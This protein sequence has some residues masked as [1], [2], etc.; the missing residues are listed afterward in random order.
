MHGRSR[1]T[2]D[3]RIPSMPGRSMSGFHRPGFHQARSEVRYIAKTGV[4]FGG[5]C[6]NRSAGGARAYIN[7]PPN[8]TSCARWHI[9]PTANAEHVLVFTGGGGAVTASAAQ[10]G[11]GPVRRRARNDDEQRKVAWYSRTRLVAQ[12]EEGGSTYRSS[13]EKLGRAIVLERVALKPQSPRVRGIA[14]HKSV[15]PLTELKQNTRYLRYEGRLLHQPIPSRQGFP[16]RSP[17]RFA[18]GA[19]V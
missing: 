10:Q 16:K 12:G 11:G 1:K 14:L 19:R 2:V 13:F 7:L 5:G 6:E 3:S 18:G 17:H 4:C 9:T 15:P 8:L